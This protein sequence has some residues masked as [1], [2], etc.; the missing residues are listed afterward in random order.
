MGRVVLALLVTTTCVT[1][2][3]A[4]DYIDDTYKKRGG[5]ASVLITQ[6]VSTFAILG[7]LSWEYSFDG[8]VEAPSFTTEYRMTF[9]SVLSALTF[10]IIVPAWRNYILPKAMQ[11]E[12]LHEDTVHQKRAK[13]DADGA[14]SDDPLVASPSAA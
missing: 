1:V 7:G 11:L 12:G 4:L 3:F 8:C 10:A 6:I 13:S 9:T 2:I 14:L 5:D